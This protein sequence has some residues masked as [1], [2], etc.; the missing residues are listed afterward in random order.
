MLWEEGANA[1]LKLIEVRWLRYFRH[2]VS[3]RLGG[4]MDSAVLTGAPSHRVLINSAV[5]EIEAIRLEPP[6]GFRVNLDLLCIYRSLVYPC[7]IRG[8]W[9]YFAPVTA[10]ERQSFGYCRLRKDQ[11][12]LRRTW[13]TG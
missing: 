11:S 1:R 10:S 13:S 4:S 8:H 5:K 2:P 9:K 12:T 3:A 7:R 6:R